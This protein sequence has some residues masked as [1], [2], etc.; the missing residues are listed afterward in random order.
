MYV[1]AKI[2]VNLLSRLGSD[3]VFSVALL[4]IFVFCFVPVGVCSFIRLFLICH[5]RTMVDLSR[6]QDA[7]E[8]C[9]CNVL[10]EGRIDM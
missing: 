4:P 6:E 2:D 3:K 9:S 7:G 1:D 8:G 10:S 5:H